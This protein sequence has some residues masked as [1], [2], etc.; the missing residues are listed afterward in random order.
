MPD[1][2]GKLTPADKQKVVDWLNKKGK[3]ANCPVCQ[4]NS[5]MVGDDLINAMLFAGNNVIIGGPTYPMAIL[6]C[7][8]CAYTRHF[9]AVPIGLLPGGEEGPP[10]G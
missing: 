9:M 1:A 6:V 3:T 8:N 4:A 2:N 7:T 10:D 5:W